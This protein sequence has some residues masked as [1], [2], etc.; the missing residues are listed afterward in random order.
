MLQR[1]VNLHKTLDH[2]FIVTF[3]EVIEDL[4]N[5]YISMEL[6]ENQTLSNYI[7]NRQGINESEARS[8]FLQ[9]ISIISYL[10]NDKK[11]NA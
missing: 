9:L 10:H 6:I 1:E 5:F 11:N 4:E 7:E 8:L 2:P 3:Y